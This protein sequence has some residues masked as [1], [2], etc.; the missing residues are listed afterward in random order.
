MLQRDS[1]WRGKIWV[2]FVCVGVHLSAQLPS[3]CELACLYINVLLLRTHV[4]GNN[5]RSESLL[6]FF[7]ALL[8]RTQNTRSLVIKPNADC[9]IMGN[10]VRRSHKVEKEGVLVFCGCVLWEGVHSRLG[11]AVLKGEEGRY[12]RADFVV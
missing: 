11:M 9:V 12:Q 1:G 7:L 10:C 8:S 4:Y 3:L 5:P 6:P 2:F